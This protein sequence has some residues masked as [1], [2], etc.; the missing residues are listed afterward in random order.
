MG[1][2]PK[3]R[4]RRTIDSQLAFRYPVLT[5]TDWKDY[6]SRPTGL[7]LSPIESFI[8]LGELQTFLELDQLFRRTFTG[9]ITNVGKP[10]SD[11]WVSFFFWKIV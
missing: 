8:L 7:R 10:E 1:N 6:G 5:T 9:P 2:K 11:K 3:P 4:W